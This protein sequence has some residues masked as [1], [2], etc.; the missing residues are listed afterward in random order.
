MVMKWSCAPLKYWKGFWQK[1]FD[2]INKF[3]SFYKEERKMKKKTVLVSEK[4]RD[5]SFF[6]ATTKTEESMIRVRLY[7]KSDKLMAIFLNWLVLVTLG[8]FV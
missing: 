1:N 5:L 6:V 3:L 8:S 7:K 4:Y 2:P